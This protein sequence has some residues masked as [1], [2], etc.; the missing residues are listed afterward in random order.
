M[1][2]QSGSKGLE[3]LLAPDA[4]LYIAANAVEFV[5]TQ[6]FPGEMATTAALLREKVDLLDYD[7][8]HTGY[9]NV[10]SSETESHTLPYDVIGENVLKCLS[11]N[12]LS[13]PDENVRSQSREVIDRFLQSRKA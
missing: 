9:D 3:M 1:N 2:V 10:L 13:N 5:N 7:K 11:L 6:L 4:E 8:L 12:S